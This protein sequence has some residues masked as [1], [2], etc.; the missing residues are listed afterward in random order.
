MKRTEKVEMVEAL[1]TKFAKANAAFITEYRGMTVEALGSLRKKVRASEGEVKVIKNRLARI[2]AK[3]SVLEGLADRFKGPI[4]LALSYKDPVAVAKAIVGELSD[5][6][7]LKVQIGILGG[8]TMDN[9]GIEA[10][11][12]LPD[13]NTLLAMLLGTLRAP[14]QNFANVMS[15][16]PRDFANVLTNV[17]D[18]KEKQS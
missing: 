16:V 7:P 9:K 13:R 6:S 12:K 15:A 10:L 17:K 1:R 8:K 3:G 5:T 4:A 18:Q 14:V 2:A 11:S